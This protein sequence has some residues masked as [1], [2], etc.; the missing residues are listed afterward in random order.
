MV[1][2]GLLIYLFNRILEIL[3]TSMIGSYMLIRGISFFLSGFP[4]EEQ[5]SYLIYYKELNQVKR[6]ITGTAFKFFIGIAVYMIVSIIVQTFTFTKEEESK[7][8][9]SGAE[10]RRGKRK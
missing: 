8:Q 10:N 4:D 7:S 5:L 1:V 3:L 2:L 9:K 6:I